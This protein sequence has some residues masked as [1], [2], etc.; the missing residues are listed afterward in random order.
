MSPLCLTGSGVFPTVVLVLRWLPVIRSGSSEGGK[1][2]IVTDGMAAFVLVTV[3]DAIWIADTS[4]GHC[5][6][7][8]L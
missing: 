7:P 6:D 4:P 3:L 2:D 5:I 8:V 1:H